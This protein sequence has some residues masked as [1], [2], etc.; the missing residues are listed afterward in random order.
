M[1]LI[2][3]TRLRI[4]SA[5]YLPQFLFYTARSWWQ[6]R[7][8]PGCLGV[9]VLRE[10]NNAFWTNTAWRDEAAMRGFMRD[11]AHAKVMPRL[12]TWC[13]E[14]SVAHWNQETAE[15]PDWDE[16]HRRMVSMGRRSRVDNP[17]PA[18][19]AFAIPAPR[20]PPFSRSR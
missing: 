13:D 7:R 15:L 10:A 16:A 11:G 1:P 20:S 3:L 8:A 2:A 6:A 9:R 18:H 12:R 17:S 19:I 5:R 4:R 14:A